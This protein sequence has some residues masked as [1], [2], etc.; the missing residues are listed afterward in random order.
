[1]IL[2]KTTLFKLTL[3]WIRVSL[4]HTKGYLG[5]KNPDL[6][7]RTKNN[8]FEERNHFY[9]IEKYFSQRGQQDVGCISKSEFALLIPIHMQM[10][11]TSTLPLPKHFLSP[12]QLSQ[13]SLIW[14][15][16]FLLPKSKGQGVEITLLQKLLFLGKLVFPIDCNSFSFSFASGG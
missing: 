9:F 3:V 6:K 8:I 10:A 7:Y 11:H 14:F 2:H 4:Q 15:T 1:M 13:F 16:S 12:F 5:T